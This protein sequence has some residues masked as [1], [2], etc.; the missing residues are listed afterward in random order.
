MIRGYADLDPADCRREYLLNYFGEAFAPPCGSCDNCDAGRV[1]AKDE[2]H[3]PFP[4]NSRVIHSSWGEGL[5]MR[6]EEDKM[7]VL[8]DTVGY[9]TLG[10]DFVLQ[11]RLLRA[12]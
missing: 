10:V 4:L 2:S 12:A 3:R 6:Y 9:R 8:F 7:V 1:V 5:V 11:E